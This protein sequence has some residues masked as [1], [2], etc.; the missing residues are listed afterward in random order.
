MND[1]KQYIEALYQ[2]E[3]HLFPE[4]LKPSL[5]T[6]ADIQVIEEKIGYTLPKQ[7]KDYLQSYQMPVLTTYLTLCGDLA[8]SLYQT[9]SKE[10]HGYIESTSDEYVVVDLV[11][12]NDAY[13]NAEQYLK[14][15]TGNDDNW[16]ILFL[17]AGYLDIGQFYFGD[18]FLFYDLISGEVLR[19]HNEDINED[20]PIEMWEDPSV[21][22]PFMQEAAWTFCPDFDT[23]LRLAC[24][25]E[26]YDEDDMFFLEQPLA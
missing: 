17:K 5:L 23:F 1:V 16:N 12:G 19:I 22:R 18:Y 3:P 10:Q 24:L 6:N 26:C 13:E 9:Y 14:K 25:N 4:G 15:W 7:Y 20:A 8:C 11:W 21:L 2:Y